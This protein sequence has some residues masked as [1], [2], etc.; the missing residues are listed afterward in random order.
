MKRLSKSCFQVLK[1]IAPNLRDV[2]GV[3]IEKL[4]E[5]G[6]FDIVKVAF[7]DLCEEPDLKAR[8][9]LDAL[10]HLKEKTLEKTNVFRSV[11]KVWMKCGNTVEKL[12]KS[13]S[14][15]FSL[16]HDMELK[17]NAELVW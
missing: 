11:F 13:S 17:L 4:L 9:H 7:G 8:F 2:N 5:E 12:W 6:K 1:L 10:K 15:I 16:F 3:E 14:T